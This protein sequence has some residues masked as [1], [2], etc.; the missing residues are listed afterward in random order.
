MVVGYTTEVAQHLRLGEFF[1]GKPGP[2]SLSEALH[3]GLPVITTR[4]AWTMPQERYNTEWVRQQRVGLVLNS[5]TAVRTAVATLREQ[6]PEF[7]A[8]V[9]RLDNRALFELPE[10]LAG[11]L[12]DA[13]HAHAN[14]GEALTRVERAVQAANDARAAEVQMS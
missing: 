13:R 14:D 10:I 12:R 11:I 7:V 2:G 5:F 1:I 9:R 3:C 4:N 8:Q 6:L